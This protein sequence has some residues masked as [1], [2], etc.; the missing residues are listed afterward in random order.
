VTTAAR[1]S[2]PKLIFLYGIITAI[3]FS[4]VETWDEILQS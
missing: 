2:N 3:L 4:D 1:T